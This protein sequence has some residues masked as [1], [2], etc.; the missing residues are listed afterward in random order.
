MVD[1]GSGFIPSVVEWKVCAFLCYKH[2]SVYCQVWSLDFRKMKQTSIY[3]AFTL[4]QS[5]G[6]LCY[7]LYVVPFK[8]SNSHVKVDFFMP[9]SRWRN[10][11]LQK[12]TYLPRGIQLISGTGHWSSHVLSSV[13]AVRFTLGL[14]TSF[15]TVLSNLCSSVILFFNLK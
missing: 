5:L 14:E 4:F 12:L 6:L 1:S 2:Q 13:S 10:G 15:R 7:V 8:L 3:W 9:F 11:G